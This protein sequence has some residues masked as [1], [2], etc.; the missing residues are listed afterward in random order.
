MLLDKGCERR[1]NKPVRQKA[2]IIEL[3][4]NFQKCLAP[5]VASSKCCRT[6]LSSSNN[7]LSPRPQRPP[8]HGF[9]RRNGINSLLTNLSA[10]SLVQNQPI[11][12]KCLVGGREGRFGWW[13][14]GGGSVSHTVQV[15]PTSI[16]SLTLAWLVSR[17]KWIHLFS[18][19]AVAAAGLQKIRLRNQLGRETVCWCVCCTA[20]PAC[21]CRAGRKHRQHTHARECLVK[22]K[23]LK[24]GL[25]F[26]GEILF[27]MTNST[28]EEM[29]LS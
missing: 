23:V 27:S 7:V 14:G 28:E 11:K 2:V 16:L 5:L 3:K 29:L 25:G 10:P 8:C 6:I 26:C 21:G 19:S 12:A 17:G 15:P 20:A 9:H 13:G 1:G 4:S 18:Q 24:L 22:N